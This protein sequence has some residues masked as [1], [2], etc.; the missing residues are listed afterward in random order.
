MSRH[1]GV[2][3]NP[4]RTDA[5]EEFVGRLRDHGCS[6]TM[7]TPDHADALGASI[8]E[9]VEQGVDAIAAI[10]GDGTQRTAAAHLVGGDVP[11]AVVPGGT[12]NLLA[13]VLGVDDFERAAAAAAGTVERTIDLGR[14]DDQIFLLNSSSGW[15]AAIIEQVDDTTKRFGRVGFVATGIVT[16]LRTRAVQVDVDL[17]DTPWF[18]GNAVTVLVLNVGQR[19]SASLHVAPE[20]AIDDGRLDVVVLRRHSIVGFLRFAVAILRGDPPPSREAAV[21]QAERITVSWPQPV[22]IQCDGDERRPAA[23][24]DYAAVPAALRIMVQAD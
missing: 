5:A 4:Q 14:M 19:G 16:W 6:V 10:G 24:I 21:G 20:A 22:S 23:T 12:V 13:R 9:L 7:T 8:D 15:D 18:S 11:L 1:I 2:V 17:D 3:V